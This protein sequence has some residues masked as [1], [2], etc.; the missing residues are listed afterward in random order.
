MS[1]E[2]GEELRQCL[3]LLAKIREEYPEGDF[4][5][6][7]IHGDMDFRYRQIKE[8]RE[9]LETW[10]K[11][12]REFAR[13][14]DSLTASEDAI[15]RFLEA[16]LQEP[17]LFSAMT[18]IQFQKRQQSLNQWAEELGTA[19]KHLNE[20]LTRTRL[21]GV[22]DSTYQLNEQYVEVISAYLKF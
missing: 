12:V 10:P 22:L 1:N 9:K 6:E 11:E 15:K 20:L 8:D 4:D 2:I 3:E 14:L 21:S 5:R 13:L 19:A 7:M 18:S 16:V 17:Q